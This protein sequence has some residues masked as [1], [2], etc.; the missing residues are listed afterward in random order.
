MTCPYGFLTFTLFTNSN[1]C[2]LFKFVVQ[3]V[4]QGEVQELVVQEDLVQ[5]VVKEEKAQVILNATERTNNVY[6]L[7]IGSIGIIN[8]SIIYFY[9]NF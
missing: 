9:S 7:L 1:Y 4:V 2:L 3:E 8:V 6:N 5:E